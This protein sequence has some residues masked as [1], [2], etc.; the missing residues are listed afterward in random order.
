MGLPENLYRAPGRNNWR[1]A[2]IPNIESM[3]EL[4]R[5]GIKRIVNLALDS[6]RKQKC[7]GGKYPSRPCEPMWAR[8]LGLEYIP[9]YVG[10]GRRL[11]RYWPKIKAAMMKGDTLIHCTYGA[12]RTG[13]VIGRFR[14]ET[15]PGLDPNA[16]HQEALK[17]GF[18]P[19]SHPGYGKG[20]DP[21]R[22]LR[23]WMLAGRYQGVPVRT[24]SKKGSSFPD[25][26]GGWKP[27]AIG[28]AAVLGLVLLLVVTRRRAA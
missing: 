10:S 26:P 11:P 23:E 16:V 2:L 4:K 25:L 27:W 18:K 3:R 6:T 19:R 15:Q 1:S 20:P 7:P 28:G 22:R 17:R 13:A 14:L 8:E 9:A 24:S 12:D 5:M 21:N